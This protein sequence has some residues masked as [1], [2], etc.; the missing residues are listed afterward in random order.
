[1][2]FARREKIRDADLC[3]AVARAER[4]LIDA[5]LGGGLIKQ[6]VPRQGQGR[7]GGFRTIIAYRHGERSFFI[8]GFAKSEMENVAG[9]EL[10]DLA[11]IGKALMALSG[12][13]IIAA[14]KAKEIQ[15]VVCYA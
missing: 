7:S 4:G 6:R 2:R 9:D 3:A 1:M 5:R 10:R 15:E 14:I 13:L 8:Y 11:D 12:P